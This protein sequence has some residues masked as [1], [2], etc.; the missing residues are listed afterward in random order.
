MDRKKENFL[1]FPKSVHLLIGL[2]NL[3]PV[4]SALHLFINKYFPSAETMNLNVK[5][6]TG[7]LT[8]A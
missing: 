4:L 3:Q 1:K 6:C 5:T 7:P 2:E 8:E